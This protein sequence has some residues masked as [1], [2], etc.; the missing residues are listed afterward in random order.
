MTRTASALAATSLGRVVHD[1][2]SGSEV[3]S[4]LFDPFDESPHVLC[5]V[6]LAADHAPRQRVEDDQR[7]LSRAEDLDEGRNVLRFEHVYG[8]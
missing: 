8:T 1:R 5:G 6:L 2:H 4:K 3:G 7:G